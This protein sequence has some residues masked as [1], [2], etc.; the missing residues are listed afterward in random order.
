MKKSLADR[1]LIITG[2]GGEIGGA[3]ALCAAEHGAKIAIADLNLEAA[4]RTVDELKMHGHKAVA[5]QTDVAHE[6]SVTEM[7][8]KTKE[9]FGRIDAVYAAAAALGLEMQQ[10]DLDVMNMDVEIWDRAMAINL[11][12]A[13]LCTKHV[14]PIMLEQGY[15]SLIYASSGLAFQGEITRTAY[16]A[17]KLGL[18]SLA[19]SVATQYGRQGVRANALQIGFV[20]PIRNKKPTLPEVV[21]LLGKQNLVPEILKPQNIADV[22]VFLA[23]PSAY[24]I[25]GQTVT[26]DGG[27]SAHTPTMSDMLEFLEKSQLKEM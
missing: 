17:S 25:T 20:P 10:K 21:A 3:T 22:V 26:A 14:L 18:A 12:G 1:V 9:A 27:F 23:S 24:A 19:R 5:I 16:S 15:G 4:K 7:A 2:G 6:S 8:A 13:M 11:R